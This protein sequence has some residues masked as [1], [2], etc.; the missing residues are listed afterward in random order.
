[1]YYNKKNH[2]YNIDFI[3]RIPFSD[4]MSNINRLSLSPIAEE[5]VNIL[6]LIDAEYS[7]ES[8]I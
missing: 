5:I 3:I 2:Y 4:R 1:V 7:K 6:K 8:L